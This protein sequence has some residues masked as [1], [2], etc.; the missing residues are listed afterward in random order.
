M[1]VKLNTV[2]LR[3]ILYVVSLLSINYSV[4]KFDPIHVRKYSGNKISCNQ[5]MLSY[6][7]RG[8]FLWFWQSKQCYVLHKYDSMFLPIHDWN[9]KKV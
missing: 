6:R 1:F 9:T 8:T 5:Y 2:S 7:R 4:F 3:N